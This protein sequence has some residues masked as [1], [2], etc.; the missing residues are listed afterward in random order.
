MMGRETYL[1]FGKCVMRS[2]GADLFYKNKK[3]VIS[4]NNI[5]SYL[6]EREQKYQ[7]LFAIKSYSWLFSL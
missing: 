4:A 5:F 2:F 1:L 6:S 7:I 3:Y